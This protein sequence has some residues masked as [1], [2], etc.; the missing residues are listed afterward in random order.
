MRLYEVKNMLL[1]WLVSLTPGSGDLLKDLMLSAHKGRDTKLLENDIAQIL[2]ILQQIA[3][4]ES[5]SVISSGVNISYEFKDKFISST[6]NN[7]AIG[8]DSLILFFNEWRSD[9]YSEFKSLPSIHQLD[10]VEQFL[11]VFCD[12]SVLREES[13]NRDEANQTIEQIELYY[14]VIDM[15]NNT[16][17]D[18]EYENVSPRIMG[19]IYFLT[20]RL[21][22]RVGNYQSDLRFLLLALNERMTLGYDLR[23]SYIDKNGSY[24]IVEY[25]FWMIFV[26][27]AVAL[28]NGH[29]DDLAIKHL[30]DFRL[31]SIEIDEK[32][33]SF[34]QESK[35]FLQD[36]VTSLS[37]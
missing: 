4:N 20:S 27:I 22:R 37:S 34:V 26:S 29:L 2:A 17:F 19:N 16:L 24:T 10:F 13:S 8:I 5:K 30:D 36:A 28:K 32:E 23:S 14:D 31:F 25:G 18:S 6:L 33:L 12:Y 11:V 9:K 3:P 21:Y 7:P 15:V 1:A 35:K